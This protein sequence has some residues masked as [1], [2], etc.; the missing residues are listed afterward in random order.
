MGGGAVHIRFEGN[1]SMDVPA[2][3]GTVLRAALE[4]DGD[5]SISHESRVVF[6]GRTTSGQGERELAAYRLGSLRGR[7]AALR[8]HDGT[9]GLTIPRRWMI[10]LLDWAEMFQEDVEDGVRE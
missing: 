8:L 7:H 10:S 3:D 5:G 2:M 4:W 6:L 9:P 1:L